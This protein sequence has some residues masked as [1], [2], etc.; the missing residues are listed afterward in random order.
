[1]R[2]TDIARDRA[3]LNT[4][5]QD[6]DPRDISDQIVERFAL[7]PRENVKRRVARAIAPAALA[8][9]Q[10]AF[11]KRLGVRLPFACDAL[12]VGER[13]A[14]D[15]S[16]SSLLQRLRSRSVK[17]ALVPGCYLGGEDVQRWLRFGVSGLDGIDVY[18]LDKRWSEIVSTLTRHYGVPIQFR[19]AGIESIPFPDDAF[20]LVATNAVLEHVRNL[21]AMVTET[22]RVLRPGGWAWHCFG[23]LYYCYGGDHCVAAYGDGHGYDHL[24]LDQEAYLRKINDQAFFD[25]CPDPNLPFW[26]RQQ[27]FS[28]AAAGEYLDLFRE[29]F[30]IRHVI[31]KIGAK[32]LAFRE[33]HS[34]DWR[35][36][37]EAGVPEGDLLVKGLCVVLRK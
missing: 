7:R 22:A 20:D 16:L 28:F 10:P 6:L 36:L 14:Y 30:T 35:R 34:A 4:S 18:S 31:V 12:A 13:F 1:M 37:L 8:L 33:K 21:R 25:A 24:L 29:Q 26:A 5:T 15:A 2:L 32:A 19:Q 3:A 27:Q 11:R 23:P 17:R 9:L